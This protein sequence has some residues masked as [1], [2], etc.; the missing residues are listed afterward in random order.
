V[1][2]LLG[3]EPVRTARLVL[4][5]FHP[6][7]WRAVQ[8]YASDADVVRYLLW[9]PNAET[10]TRAFLARAIAQARRTPRQQYEL[11]VTLADGGELIGAVAVRTEDRTHKGGSMGY[12]FRRD[13]WGRGYATEAARAIL[14]V[15]FTHLD[16][17]R[18][19]AMCIPENVPSRRVLEKIGMRW[20]GHLHENYFVRGRWYDSLLFAILRHEWEAARA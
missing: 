14:A 8:R 11:A 6:G 3:I 19:W 12:A 17:H 10:E 1:I 7:D 20:E 13:V 18:I 16:L 5:D 2:G 4:R 9:G 15:G